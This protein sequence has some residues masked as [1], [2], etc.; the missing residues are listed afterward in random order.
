MGIYWGAV[1]TYHATRRSAT[2]IADRC[3]ASAATWTRMDTP[4][5]TDTPI[6]SAS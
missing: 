5:P 3:P 6:L 2:S 1:C 4:V